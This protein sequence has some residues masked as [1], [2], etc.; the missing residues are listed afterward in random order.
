MGF[1]DRVSVPFS[2]ISVFSVAKVFVASEAQVG[3]IT[4]EC[5]TS[6]PVP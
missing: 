6:L 4:P 1:S 5:A 2:V 3:I